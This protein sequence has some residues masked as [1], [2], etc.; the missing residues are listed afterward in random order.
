MRTVSVRLEDLRKMEITIGFSGENLH[1]K[2]I[3]DCKRVFDEYPD[4][5]QSLAVQPPYGEPYPAVTSREG[6]LVIWDVDETDLVDVGRGEFQLSFLQDSV[7]V[8]TFI[9]KT[10]ICRS[11]VP[12][13]DVPDPISDWIADANE[14]LGTI[15][16]AVADAEAAQAGAEAAQA[17]AE[18]AQGKAETAQGK[19]EDAE[20][21]AED[22]RRRAVSAQGYA[23]AAQEAAET[24]QGKAEDAQGYAEAAQGLAEDA[25]DLAQGYA[26]T[27]NTKAGEAAGSATAAGGS[28]TAANRDALK[29]EGY[30]VGQQN[31]TDVS[32]GTYYHN[33]AKY[34]A[35]QA[36]GSATTADTKAGEAAGSASAASGSATAANT[37]A[38]KAEGYATGKQNG[39]AVASGSPYYHNNAKYYADEAAGSAAAAEAAAASLVVDSELDDESVNPVQNKVITG[40]LEAKQTNIDNV[41]GTKADVINSE[42]TNEVIAAFYDGADGLPAAI[43]AKI[44]LIQTGE[45]DPSPSN[46]R[47]IS[48]W[49]A[50]N[51]VVN[52]RNLLPNNN[53]GYDGYSGVGK[54]ID[55]NGDISNQTGSFVTRYF[56]VKPNTVYTWGH[57]S[58]ETSTDDN[59]TGICFYTVEKVFI[60]G[61]KLNRNISRQITTPANAYW[62][63]STQRTVSSGLQRFQLIEGTQNVSLVPTAGASYVV[64]FPETAGTVY[65]GTLTINKDGTGKLIVERA[66]SIPT[67]E[68][69]GWTLVTGTTTAWYRNFTSKKRGTNTAICSHFATVTYST[70]DRIV[71]NSTGCTTI[72]A[73]QDYQEAQTALG[74]PVQILRI[75][76]TPVEYDL[77]AAQ[78]KTLYGFNNIW[79]DTGDIVELDY[80]ADTKTYVDDRTVKTVNM[81]GST[82]SITGADNTRYICGTVSTISIT[83]PASGCV[84][85]IFTSG[86]TPA[87]LTVPNTVK[88]PAWFDPSSLAASTTYEINILDGTLGAVMAWT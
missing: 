32:S 72:E 25:R 60:S 80:P 19:A 6:D 64:T 50:A 51:I 62:C 65:G 47:P 34:Y 7:V 79:A 44:S 9:G 12:A 54:Y 31:G 49:T 11:I 35:Q 43:T 10:V 75:L 15:Q 88:W 4:A 71:L 63:R 56:R 24:A 86:T 70:S 73:L 48:G 84:D 41:K 8:K 30:A 17:A 28:A 23:E 74:T 20:A 18:T 85:V 59:A 67:F 52:S 46:I 2:M 5:V 16:G 36:S 13:G 69:S 1:T 42:V 82:P 58:E 38:L 78:V 27:A 53:D 57:G 76:A 61:V 87:V 45:G 39:T 66:M 81:S 29:A 55:Q 26:A 14:A 21:G 77:T 83:P 3:I 33:N 37:D 40:A 22:A 68:E